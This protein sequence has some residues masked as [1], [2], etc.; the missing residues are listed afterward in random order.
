MRRWRANKIAEDEE[1]Y[2]NIQRD[3]RARKRQQQ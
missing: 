3:Y 1:S 2:L